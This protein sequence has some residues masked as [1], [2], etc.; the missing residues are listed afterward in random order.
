M[1]EN[2]L[3]PRTPLVYASVQG[4]FTLQYFAVAAAGLLY[5][6]YILT[7]GDEITLIWD[8]KKTL[9]SYIF[10]LN[11]YLTLLG[12]TP[13][14]LGL[15]S[16]RKVSGHLEYSYSITHC[17]NIVHAFA[18]SAWGL[19]QVRSTNF[20]FGRV[21]ACIP[22]A[23]K[24]VLLFDTMVFA[25]TLYK[26]YKVNKEHKQVGMQSGLIK[27]LIRDGTLYYAVMAMANLSN[28]LL[29]E[30]LSDSFFEQSAG[31]NS[32]LTHT[33]S[34]TLLSRIILNLRLEGSRTDTNSTRFSSRFS[35]HSRSHHDDAVLG[36]IMLAPA[37][38]FSSATK[39][40]DFTRVGSGGLHSISS[41]DTRV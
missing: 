9:V 41:V 20:S 13:H 36:D 3:L 7:S 39:S 1:L 38:T 4:F 24:S 40:S 30:M 8:Q 16:V 12:Y 19:S 34:S 22:V 29:Y 6:D 5:F 31:N 26:S 14:D 2:H 35:S 10:L 21:R 28:L 11:R 17:A 37:S 33:I 23:L 25:L 15:Y 27:L 32:I 18:I